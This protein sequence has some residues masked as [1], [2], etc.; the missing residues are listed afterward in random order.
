MK[1]I[2]RIVLALAVFAS[3][4]VFGGITKAEAVVAPSSLGNPFQH[5]K[6]APFSRTIKVSDG[7][8]GHGFRENV[9]PGH[10]AVINVYSVKVPNNCE[11]QKNYQHHNSYYRNRSGKAKW[12]NGKI[13]SVGT[14]RINMACGG[15]SH[16][17]R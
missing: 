16:S 4:L 12:Y 5:V 1:K 10:T 11:L 14:T 7:P 3:M 2:V 17:W 13:S 15:G 9:K 8:W 6:V